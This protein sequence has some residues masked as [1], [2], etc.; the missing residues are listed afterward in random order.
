MQKNESKQARNG[1]DQRY[2]DLRQKLSKTGQ[3]SSCGLDT[4][5]RMPESKEV[6]IL[7]RI[8]LTRTADLS[9]MN[10]SRNSYSPWTLDHIRRRSPD[11]VLTTSRGLSPPRNVSD[12]PRR[13]LSRTYDDVRTVPYMSKDV[14]GSARP[15]NATP[16]MTK[17]TLPS[18][19]AKLVQPGPPVLG[20][21]PSTSIVS[22]S[23]Y[24]V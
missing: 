14:N 13:P 16:Y 6:S 9:Q 24:T 8:P 22:K 17:P 19:S 2:V 3:P 1:D 23:S 21:L 11:R 12:I 7:G 4:R 15:V 20:Q 18:G 5:Q 10:S